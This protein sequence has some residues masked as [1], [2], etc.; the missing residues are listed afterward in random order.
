LAVVAL[1]IAGAAET[2][3]V[4]VAFPVPAL[5]VALKV[6]EEVPAVVGVPEINPVPLLMVSPVGKPVAP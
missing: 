5:L 6:T 1:V 4:S 2:V 3:R